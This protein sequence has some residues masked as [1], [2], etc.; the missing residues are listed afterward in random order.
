MVEERASRNPWLTA[1]VDA[2]PAAHAA[3]QA[4][5]RDVT[6]YEVSPAR[7]ERGEFVT[8]ATAERMTRVER[9]CPDGAAVLRDFAAR[10]R[11]GS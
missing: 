10:L 9:C 5:W 4:F 11:G 6:G 1:F 8:L 2:D 3:E 7:G